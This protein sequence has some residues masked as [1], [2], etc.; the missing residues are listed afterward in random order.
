MGAPTRLSSNWGRAWVAGCLAMVVGCGGRSSVVEG[1]HAGDS[2]ALRDLQLMR[3]VDRPLPELHDVPLPKSRAPSQRRVVAVAHA[4]PAPDPS[5]ATATRHDSAT[6]TVTRPALDTATSAALPSTAAAL[7]PGVA[8]GLVTAG[9]VIVLNP[10]VAVCTRFN[11]VGDLFVSTLATPIV[12]A[13]GIT[14]PAGV[15]VSMQ[16]TALHRTPGGGG[17]LDFAVRN[18]GHLQDGAI[19]TLAPERSDVTAPTTQ[20]AGQATTESTPLGTCVPRGGALRLTLAQPVRITT[21]THPH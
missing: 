20:L 13:G 14:I 18:F 11:A 2:A 1:A 16:I 8:P 9:T 17:E 3:R 12:G 10:H 21:D 7:D 4:A 15:I 19:A 6:T 5:I